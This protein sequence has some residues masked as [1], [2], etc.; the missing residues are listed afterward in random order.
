MLSPGAREPPWA[1]RKLATFGVSSAATLVTICEYESRG[2]SA[3]M[4]PGLPPRFDYKIT[5]QSNAEG[6]LLSGRRGQARGRGR[7]QSVAGSSTKTGICREVLVWY[8]A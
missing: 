6:A 4:Y 2:E 3:A 7:D 1:T 8:S 5:S